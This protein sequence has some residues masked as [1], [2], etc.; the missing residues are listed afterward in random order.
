MSRSDR[1]ERLR[2]WALEEGFDHAGVARLEPSEHGEYFLRWLEV[3][4]HAGMDY[5]ARRTDSRVDPRRI[6]PGARSALCVTLRY[7]PLA[8]EEESEGD[9]WPRVAR[10]AR[11][12]DYH[13]I[14]KK[15]LKR[16]ARRIEEGYPGSRVRWY[17]DTGPVLE[18]EIAQRAGLGA[19]GK[20]TCLLREDGGSY[21]FLGE[22][23]LS[24]ELAPDEAATDMC[25]S[26]TLCLEACP[27]DALPEP[28]QL[29]SARCI[30]YWTIEHRG[31]LPLDAREMIG[32]W[33][34][35]CD[36]CQEVCPWNR[37]PQE[38]ADHPDLRL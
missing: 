37:R 14:M 26:C 24:L 12:R 30:S 4:R 15:G 22:L 2:R 32:D 28:F 10:Y 17:V 23:F 29:D 13:R 19:V 5:L 9:L 18:R 36:V 21:F 31:H 11:G 35:G 1:T 3:G 20:N 27:T 8:G 16:L 7:A 33:V 34:F 6:F 25:G 38:P